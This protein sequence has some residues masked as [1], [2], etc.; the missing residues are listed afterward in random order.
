MYNNHRGPTAYIAMKS[1]G[2]LKICKNIFR[3]TTINIFQVN[4]LHFTLFKKTG[5]YILERFLSQIKF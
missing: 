2:I 4:Y 1:Y 5:K 3:I